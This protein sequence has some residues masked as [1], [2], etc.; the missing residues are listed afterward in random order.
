MKLPVMR[1]PKNPEQKVLDKMKADFKKQG[2]DE[3]RASEAVENVKAF[4][5]LNRHQRRAHLAKLRKKK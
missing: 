4:V 1:P 3:T 5:S 2:L